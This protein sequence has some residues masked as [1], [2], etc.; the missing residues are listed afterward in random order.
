MSLRSAGWRRSNLVIIHCHFSHLFVIPTEA[1]SDLAK[2]RNL[3]L[4]FSE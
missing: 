1:K 4:Y 3:S 2:R